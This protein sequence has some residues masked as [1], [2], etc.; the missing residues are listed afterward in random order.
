M[1]GSTLKSLIIIGL[2]CSLFTVIAVFFVDE[3]YQKLLLFYNFLFFALTLLTYYIFKFTSKVQSLATGGMLL[4]TFVKMIVGVG[5]FLIT[6][7]WVD[8]ENLLYSVFL[9]FTY[10]AFYTIFGTRQIIKDKQ[11]NKLNKQKS[12]DS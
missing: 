9:F 2:T 12:E 5:A 7:K 1:F 6:I 4:S 8:E 10:Y 11:L 3:L